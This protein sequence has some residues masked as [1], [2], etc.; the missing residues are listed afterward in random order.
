[1][2]NLHKFFTCI[3]MLLYGTFHQLSM[4]SKLEKVTIVTVHMDYMCVYMRWVPR[5]QVIGKW[6]LGVVSWIFRG[7][8]LN[9]TH[10]MKYNSR[11]YG[12]S[13]HCVAISIIDENSPVWLGWLMMIVLSVT[14]AR[15][16]SIANV[17][18]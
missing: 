13:V 7:R 9:L 10:K 4:H 12:P 5:L 1:M 2:T 18:V 6:L 3:K 8:L 11:C 16:F 17:S 15:N 14:L